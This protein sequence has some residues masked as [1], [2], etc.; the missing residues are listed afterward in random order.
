MG[1]RPEGSYVRYV[2]VVCYDFPGIGTAGVI[3]TYQ[4]AKDLSSFGWQ[5]II[6]T[7]QPCCG[8]QED[9]IEYSDGRLDCPKITVQPPRLLVPFRNGHQASFKPLPEGSD[10]GNGLL[11]PV[12]RFVTQ[13]AL[14]D[15][16]IG[17]LPAAVQ[18]GLQIAR[19]YPVRICLSVSPRPTAHF[20]AR[21]VVRRLGVPW[22]ADFALPWSDAYWLAGRPRFIERLDRQLES[23]ALRSAQH[24]TVAY[25]DLARS[26]CARFGDDWKNKISVIPTGFNNDLFAQE[27]MPTP[28]KFT[29]VYP[30]NHFC[31]EGR[32]GEYF[33]KAI[34]EWIGLNPRLGNRI[35]F[36]FIG[37][38]DDELLRQRA[39]MAHPEVVRI[40][41]LISHRACI[42]AIQSSHMCVV[43]TVGNR[44]PDK[45]YECMRAGRWILALTDPGTDLE[46]L[47]RRYSRGISVPAQDIS[48]IRTLLQRA[49]QRSLSENL[50]P[51]QVDT[52]LHAYSSKHSAAMVA[53]IFDGLVLAQQGQTYQG[54]AQ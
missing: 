32:H 3:R 52:F 35:E 9:N 4:L 53:R 12:I 7:A 42:R 38:P 30:G 44:I 40:E 51:L 17:W 19:D 36:V 18:R 13:L 29:V 33:L 21:R 41:P 10:N 14:P 31:D 50:E 11:K 37:K 26:I 22:V 47:V 43:N 15:G 8:D 54:A 48:G 46:K 2:L 1:E 28:A 27:G 23:S 16:K 45:V 6:L 39:A 49:F 25:A 34:D 20:V 24:V 5:P